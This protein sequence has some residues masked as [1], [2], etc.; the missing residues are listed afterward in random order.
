MWLVAPLSGPNTELGKISGR[1]S[2]KQKQAR[3]QSLLKGEHMR[4]A[5]IAVLS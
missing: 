1:V 5:S 2:V 4:Q 3:N